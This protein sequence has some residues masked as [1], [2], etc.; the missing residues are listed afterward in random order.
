MKVF[1]SIPMA[2]RSDSEVRREMDMVAESIKQE[3]G[4]QVEIIDS[5]ITETPPEDSG[6]GSV[7]YLAK[8][9]EML[10]KA[11]LAVFVGEWKSARGC[12]IEHHTA[13]LYNISVLDFQLP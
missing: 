9:I 4:D 3:Y 1:I 7:W 2:G 11:N 10:G 12:V 6:R 5:F 13:T 8:S